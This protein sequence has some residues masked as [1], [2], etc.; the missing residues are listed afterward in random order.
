MIG[1]KLLVWRHQVS[2]H[3]NLNS[4]TVESFLQQIQEQSSQSSHGVHAIPHGAHIRD[5]EQV[6]I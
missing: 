4:V 1:S 6:E 3:V 2:D 5:D